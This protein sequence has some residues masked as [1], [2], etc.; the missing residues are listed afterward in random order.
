VAGAADLFFNLM[1]NSA[2]GN[3]AEYPLL[4]KNHENGGKWGAEAC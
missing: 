3:C 1:E 4:F 2:C